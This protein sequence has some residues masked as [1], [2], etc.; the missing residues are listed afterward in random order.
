MLLITMLIFMHARSE[1]RRC[2]IEQLNNTGTFKFSLL[3]VVNF[4][5]IDGC[6]TRRVVAYLT[7]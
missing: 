5:P 2:D 6:R 7:I 3:S 1:N 4:P